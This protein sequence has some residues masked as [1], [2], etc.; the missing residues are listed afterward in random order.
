MMLLTTWLDCGKRVI[1]KISNAGSR[2]SYGPYHG[3]ELPNHGV[4][5][6]TIS[7]R[8]TKSQHLYASRLVLQLFVPNPCK[9]NVDSR[10]KKYL[11]IMPTKG[12]YILEVWRVSS[13]ISGSSLL[14]ITINTMPMGENSNNIYIYT[15]PSTFFAAAL[16]FLLQGQFLLQRWEMT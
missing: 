13:N 5:F 15:I 3:L 6:R 16:H 7:I 14:I 2:A 8:R 11:E 4:N 12:Q 1:R 9:P 10:M